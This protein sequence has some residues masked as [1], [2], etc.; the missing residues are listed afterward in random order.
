MRCSPSKKEG[1]LHVAVVSPTIIKEQKLSINTN[2]SPNV[3]KIVNLEPNTILPTMKQV[4]ND[5][6]FSPNK[7]IIA[8]PDKNSSFETANL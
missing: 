1:A 8:T 6:T 7:V 5:A 3:L 4:I 2:F